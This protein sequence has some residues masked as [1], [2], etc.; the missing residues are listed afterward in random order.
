MKSL[1]TFNKRRPL[2]MSRQ[3]VISSVA[4]IAGDKTILSF[5]SFQGKAKLCAVHAQNCTAEIQDVQTCSLRVPSELLLHSFLGPWYD[6]I[7][8]CRNRK[9]KKPVV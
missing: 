3:A 5:S 6:A 9:V 7:I 1:L 4:V 2:A 8:T